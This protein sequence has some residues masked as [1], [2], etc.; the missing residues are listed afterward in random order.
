MF[1]K[2]KEF[3]WRIPIMILVGVLVLAGG[4]YVGSKTIDRESDKQ[5]NVEVMKEKEKQKEPSK[6]EF[7]LSENCEIW[8][9]KVMEDGTVSE[10]GPMMI[11][12]VPKDLIGKSEDEIIDY[13]TEKYPDRQVKEVD[14]YEITL[15]EKI[16]F[17][18]SSRANKFSIEENKGFICIYKYDDNGERSLLENTQIAI[19][20]LPQIAQDELKSGI[21]VETQNDVYSKLEDFGS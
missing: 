17:K 14:K 21:V 2:K 3:P 16:T 12:S 13:L 20:S 9:E 8:V 18:D 11:G 5:S 15:E 19:A 10:D 7:E 4:I 1:E 6:L